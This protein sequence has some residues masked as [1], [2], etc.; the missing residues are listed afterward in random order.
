MPKPVMFLDVDGVLNAFRKSPWAETTKTRVY[1]S[2]YEHGL[3]IQTSPLLGQRLLE[4]E[5]DIHWLTTWREEANVH[6]S[7]LVG[8]PQDLPVVQWDRKLG[9]GWSITG[10]GQA[11]NQWREEN[12]DHPFIW[13]DD[14]HLGDPLGVIPVV[15]DRGDHLIVGPHGA[16]GL[17]PEHIGQ[18]EDWVLNLAVPS[19][20]GSSTQG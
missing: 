10:K 19:L 4:L 3:L 8:L 20:D 13:V 17:L 14:E 18:I 11:I 12:P 16:E 6:I 5:V 2:G 9:E 1:P 15:D 7:P